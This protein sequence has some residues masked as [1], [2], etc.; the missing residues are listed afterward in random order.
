MLHWEL[1]AHG[2]LFAINCVEIESIKRKASKD[3]YTSFTK[4]F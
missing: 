3:I 2:K 4:D 1:K